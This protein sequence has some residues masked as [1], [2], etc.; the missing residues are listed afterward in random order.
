MVNQQEQKNYRWQSYLDIVQLSLHSF[1]YHKVHGEEAN[2][3]SFM[4]STFIFSKYRII[5]LS[6][7]WCSERLDFLK[8]ILECVLKSAF[9]EDQKFGHCLYIIITT[10]N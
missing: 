6:V 7:L 1:M 9:S 8:S 10:R 4:F 2:T 5:S 3:V